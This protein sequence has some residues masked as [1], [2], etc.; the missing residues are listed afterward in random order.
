LL[1]ANFFASGQKMYCYVD[2]L[3]TSRQIEQG[4][5]LLKNQGYEP[6]SKLWK[7]VPQQAAGY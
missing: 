5:E 3:F 2:D 4:V 1:W 7:Q 6:Q